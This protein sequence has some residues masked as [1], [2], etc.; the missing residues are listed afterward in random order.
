[1]QFHT[2]R[3][4]SF[5]QKFDLERYKNSLHHVPHCFILD[6]HLNSLIISEFPSI[7]TRIYKKSIF[8]W[9]WQQRKEKKPWQA[10]SSKREEEVHWTC[11]F[12]DATITKTYLENLSVKTTSLSPK[13][14]HRGIGNIKNKAFDCGEVIRSLVQR[15]QFTAS[16]V[17]V[18]IDNSVDR[19]K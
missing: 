12:R 9:K 15:I 7:F 3:A 10:L 8:N 1:M 17:R 18:D 16:L 4:S 13:N 19:F 14:F 11:Q 6:V 2:R 5:D